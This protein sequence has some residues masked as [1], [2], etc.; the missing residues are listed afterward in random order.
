M[1][2]R[3]RCSEKRWRR[4]T[5]AS[6]GGATSSVRS[7]EPLHECYATHESPSVH[8]VYPHN[9]LSFD[10]Q[11]IKSPKNRSTTYALDLMSKVLKLQSFTVKHSLTAP[12]L[13]RQ[14]S[15]I[16]PTASTFDTCPELYLSSHKLYLSYPKLYLSYPELYLTYPN[17]YLSYPKLY[18]SSPK[19]SPGVS[20]PSPRVSGPS[21][22]FWTRH[23]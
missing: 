16:H 15:D 11:H 23:L 19:T 10:I 9:F 20:D 4:P 2:L 6:G 1:P 17:L 21:P 14:A 8:V 13:P 22:I 12:I 3:R 7:K 18:L 5:S